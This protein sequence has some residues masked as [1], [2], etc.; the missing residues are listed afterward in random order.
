MSEQGER[1]RDLLAGSVPIRRD[2]ST[3]GERRSIDAPSGSPR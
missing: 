2:T 1:D 3:T